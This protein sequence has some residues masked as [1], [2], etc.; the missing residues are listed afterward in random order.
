V[1]AIAGA[2]IEE[3]WEG[4]TPSVMVNGF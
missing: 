1:K 4:S 3:D 2:L